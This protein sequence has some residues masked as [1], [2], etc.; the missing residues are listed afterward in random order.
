MQEC[1]DEKTAKDW[2]IELVNLIPSGKVAYYGQ[3]AQLIG[4]K[5]GRPVSAQVAGWILSGMKENEWN[6]CP[7]QRVVA[8]DGFIATIKLGYKGVLQKELLEKEG[9]HFTESNYIDMTSHCLLWEEWAILANLD[10]EKNYL[11]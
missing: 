11:F 9:V 6:L 1:R 7:W 4:L 5:S 2:L 10:K 8:K 3:I